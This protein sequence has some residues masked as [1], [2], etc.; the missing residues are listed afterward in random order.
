MS[1]AHDFLKDPKTGVFKCWICGARMSSDNAYANAYNAISSA[2]ASIE[3][4][5]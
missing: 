5:S 1:H 4:E 2:M 3:Y